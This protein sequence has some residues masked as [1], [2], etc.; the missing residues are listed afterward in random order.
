VVGLDRNGWPI[1]VGIRIRDLGHVID[2]EKSEI[3]VFITLEEATAPMKKEAM[4]KGY[5]TSKTGKK[6]YARIQILTVEELL[7]G[8][9]PNI[10]FVLKAHKRAEESAIQEKLF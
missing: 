3:G 1:C 4:Q 6:D 10:P 2:R 8:K 5:Y 9:K 7:E